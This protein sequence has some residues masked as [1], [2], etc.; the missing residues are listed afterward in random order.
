MTTL[1][2]SRHLLKTLAQD[3]WADEFTNT[4]IQVSI[5]CLQNELPFLSN[6]P[7]LVQDL[8]LSIDKQAHFSNMIPLLPL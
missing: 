8:I 5:A 4:E 1:E 3:K 2:F 6:N 7:L